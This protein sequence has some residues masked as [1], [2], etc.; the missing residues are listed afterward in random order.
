M[1]IKSLIGSGDK[2]MGI[3]LPFA[4][5]GIVLNVFYPQWFKMNI[6]NTGIIIGIILL[7]VGVP[8]WL[9]A[10]FQMVKYVPQ[11]MLITK[12]A[13]RI[14]LHPIYTSVA[15]FVIPGVSF[16]FDTWLGFAIGII[17]YVISRIFR[18]QEERKLDDV[19]MEEYRT[20][21]SKVILKWI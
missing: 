19:F 13:F 18:G 7:V 2:I 12:G 9:T 3:T 16:L 8:L 4:I 21:R 11:N 5:I 20:Y 6:G 14:M 17:L 15:L 10:V 1:N